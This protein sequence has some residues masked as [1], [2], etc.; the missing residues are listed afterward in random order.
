MCLDCQGC[1][2]AL[3]RQGSV[4]VPMLLTSWVL[5]QSGGL[6]IP[7]T[8]YW[9]DDTSLSQSLGRAKTKSFHSWIKD[10]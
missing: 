8:Q 5:D 6:L 2:V 10:V 7:L 1:I 3:G 4:V 9:D